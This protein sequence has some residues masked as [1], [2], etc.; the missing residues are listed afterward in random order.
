MK[1]RRAREAVVG[2]SGVRGWGG[3]DILGRRMVGRRSDVPKL[4]APFELVTPYSG[5][6]AVCGG[7]WEGGPISEIRE[8]SR[9][10]IRLD[11]PAPS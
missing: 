9:P 1:G 10:A 2:G 4:G 3:G 7:G 6:L 11:P 8:I 5:G